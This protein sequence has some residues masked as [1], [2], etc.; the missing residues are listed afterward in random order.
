MDT[1]TLSLVCLRP[2]VSPA[3][4]LFLEGDGRKEQRNHHAAAPTH[5]F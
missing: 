4:E 2:H 5:P 3:A 1:S